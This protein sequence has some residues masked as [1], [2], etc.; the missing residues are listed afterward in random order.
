[1]PNGLDRVQT[2]IQIWSA[3]SQ[4]TEI[5]RVEINKIL[6]SIQYNC[7]AIY[8]AMPFAL[9]TTDCNYSNNK[10]MTQTQFFTFKVSALVQIWT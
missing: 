10:R 3:F 4:N 2:N 7:I 8:K 6:L 1:M 5:E 9:N